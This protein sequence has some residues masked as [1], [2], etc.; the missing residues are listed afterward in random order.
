MHTTIYIGQEIDA[1]EGWRHIQTKA[2]EKRSI[3]ISNK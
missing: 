1:K 3:D 2:R